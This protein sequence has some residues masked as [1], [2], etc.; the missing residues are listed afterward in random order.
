VHATIVNGRLLYQD[1]VHRG[2]WPETVLRSG[3]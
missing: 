3:A 2:A 1:D